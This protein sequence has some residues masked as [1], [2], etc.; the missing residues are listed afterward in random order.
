MHG[1]RP[2]KRSTRSCKIDWKERGR[3]RVKPKLH[4]EQGY[5]PKYVETKAHLQDLVVSRVKGGHRVSLNTNML[6]AFFFGFAVNFILPAMSVVF[7][8]NMD[9]SNTESFSMV[10]QSQSPIGKIIAWKQN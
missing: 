10:N 3:R 5:F 7:E 1:S 4:K 9:A 6:K 8:M 2:T